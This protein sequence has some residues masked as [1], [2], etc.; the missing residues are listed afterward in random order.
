MFKK[1]SIRT[2]LISVMAIVISIMMAAVTIVTIQLFKN[3]VKDI[4]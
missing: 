3:E 2:K 1:V 4:L